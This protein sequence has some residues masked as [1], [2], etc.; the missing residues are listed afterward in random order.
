MWVGVGSQLNSLPQVPHAG[1]RCPT[2]HR[3]C[4]VALHS[5]LWC[6]LPV[7]TRESA[8]LCA[9]ALSSDKA[10]PTLSSGAF[11]RLIEAFKSVSN[12]HVNRNAVV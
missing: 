8:P 9:Q 3:R 11:S 1:C 6:L 7:S 4:T 12:R 2:S 5:C 10:C